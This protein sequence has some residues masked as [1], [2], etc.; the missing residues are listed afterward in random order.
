MRY[1]SAAHPDLLVRSADGSIRRHPSTACMLGALP[2]DCFDASA[3]DARFAVGESL[4][5]YTDGLTE[6]RSAAGAMLDIDGVAAMLTRTDDPAEHL[7]TLR[8][9][10][11]SQAQDDCM[12][13]RVKRTNLG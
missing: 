13:V 11:A 9:H 1:A 8:R 10:R 4:L 12:I 3:E 2:R 7:A 6:S 5:L